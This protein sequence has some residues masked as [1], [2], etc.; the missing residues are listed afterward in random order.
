[1]T[2]VDRG[3][4]PFTARA[5][6]A[7]TSRRMD[8]PTPFRYRWFVKG[9]V[10]GFFGLAVDNLVQVLVISALCKTLCGMTDTIIFGRILPG[11]AVSLLIGNVFYSLH[12]IRVA[13]RDRNLG[14]TALPFGIN[15]PNRFRSFFF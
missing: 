3:D 5:C 11:V 4:R 8:S 9:D 13:R 10:D 12:A 7:I 14:C 15:T 2:V 1:A 6:H